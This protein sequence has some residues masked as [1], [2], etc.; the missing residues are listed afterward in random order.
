MSGPA[1]SAARG[2]GPMGQRV[3]AFAATRRCARGRCWPPWLGWRAC[4]D[5]LSVVVPRFKQL[6]HVRTGAA[7]ARTPPEL[8]AHRPETV[9]G[10]AQA[11][12]TSV[13]DGRRLRR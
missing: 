2:T 6:T 13:A 12:A 3:L 10:G 11:D 9:L 5:S 8:Y 1:A 7:S 4:G